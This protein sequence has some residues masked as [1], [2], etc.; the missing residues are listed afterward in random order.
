MPSKREARRQG[1]Q[2]QKTITQITLISVGVL[3]AAGIFYILWL[4]FR[5][6]AGE[7]VAIMAETGHVELDTDPGPYNSDPPTSGK[8][9]EVDLKPGFYEE[10]S[11]LTYAPYPEGYLVHN[12]EHGYVIF[13]YDCTDLDEEGCQSLKADILSVMDSKN[14]FKTIAFPRPSMGVPVVMTS[15]GQMQ[16][17]EQFDIQQANA[18]YD[19]NLNN[20]P[21]PMAD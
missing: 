5:P 14:N 2:R 15:W 13:W 7:D 12:L 21:E 4:A 8:H 1:K 19:R 18:F 16:R 11:L 17:F 20:A 9:Y 10:D 6:A 3:V